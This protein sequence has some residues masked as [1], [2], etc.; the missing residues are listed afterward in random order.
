MTTDAIILGSGRS[1]RMQGTDKLLANLDG[2]PVITWSIRAFEDNAGIRSVVI[3][4]ST[5]NDQKIR[6]FLRSSHF[7][8]IHSIVAGGPCRARSVLNALKA[9]EDRPPDFVAV[10]DGARPL[11]TQK[12]ILNG[13]DQLKVHPAAIPA[14]PA[15]DTVKILDQH[16]RIMRSIPRSTVWH[17]QTPQF[18]RY[19]DILNAHLVQSDDLESFTD[20]ASLL[21]ASGIPIQAYQGDPENLKITTAQDLATAST[22][23]ERRHEDPS[24]ATSTPKQKKPQ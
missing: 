10:H 19:K 9:L 5:E 11:L 16:Q 4:T 18:A 23:V 14:L 21:E 8:K 20:D 17:A 7:S 3:T 1:K 6:N 15:T 12:I 2:N 13:L 24:T 22:I